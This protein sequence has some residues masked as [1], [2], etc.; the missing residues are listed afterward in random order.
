MKDNVPMILEREASYT[1]IRVLAQ[2]NPEMVFTSLAH[3]IDVGLLRKSF[4]EIRSSNAAGVDKVTA[5]EYA[6]NL[7]TN[8]YNL[9][10]RLCRGQYV[11]M[12]VK[13]I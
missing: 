12:P 7:D 9:H 1:R 13:R 2:N 5:E 4:R 10:E 3:R 11:A 6:E 8:L